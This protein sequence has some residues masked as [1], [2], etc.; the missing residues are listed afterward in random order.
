[1]SHVLVL[2]NR[3]NHQL[4]IEVIGS[5]FAYIDVARR[6]PIS[7]GPHGVNPAK[8]DPLGKNPYGDAATSLVAD[9]SPH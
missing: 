8:A 6:K 5:V 7:Q 2:A 4:S 9:N 3:S 1:M